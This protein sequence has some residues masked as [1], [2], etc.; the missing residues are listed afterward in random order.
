MK[1]HIWNCLLLKSPDAYFLRTLFDWCNYR[2]G[3]I[4]FYTVKRLFT[5]QQMTKADDLFWIMLFFFQVKSPT[6][7]HSLAAQRPILTQVIGL[8]MF[9]P[10]KKT[11]LIFVKCPDVARDTRILVHSGN[12]CVHTDTT[13]EKTD[14]QRTLL[15]CIPQVP[16]LKI[17]GLIVCLRQ[18]ALIWQFPPVLRI[19]SPRCFT[20]LYQVLTRDTSKDLFSYKDLHLI[21]C[22]HPPY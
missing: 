5:F 20:F 19:C 18:V 14:K 4:W 13:S 10:I 21:L 3:L 8:N 11:S 15:Q 12:M 16:P 7:V 6:F 17:M 2:S 9:A 22:Y 1:N